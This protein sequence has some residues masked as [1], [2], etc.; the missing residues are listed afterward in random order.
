MNIRRMLPLGTHMRKCIVCGTPIH[1]ISD[2]LTVHELICL[3]I[4]HDHQPTGGPMDATTPE[5][6]LIKN[7]EAAVTELV[8]RVN[9][10]VTPEK[11]SEAIASHTK[12]IISRTTTDSRAKLHSLFDALQKMDDFLADNEER[13]HAE[14]DRHV[15]ISN[16]AY[17]A[18]AMLNE[19]LDKWHNQIEFK[20]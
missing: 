4:N 14:I 8:A 11:V 6:N 18:A 7:V 13:L 15:N 19:T 3:G 20:G 17:Q 1:A 9:N 10:D 12:S 5:A 16:G 2:A